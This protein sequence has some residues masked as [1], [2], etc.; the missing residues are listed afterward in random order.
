MFERTLIPL[1]ATLMA[2]AL[3]VVVLT[4]TGEPPVID[5]PAPPWTR[6][7]VENPTG[8]YR[9]TT[10]GWEET[11]NWR[12]NGEESRVKFIDHVHPLTWM[13]FVI[14]LACGL[15]ILVSDE[16]HVRRLLPNSKSQ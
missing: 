14:L 1:V 4:R 6:A 10:N 7:T 3:T 9:F 2:A 16:E 13:L 5:V 12:I 8:S 15:A 11:A